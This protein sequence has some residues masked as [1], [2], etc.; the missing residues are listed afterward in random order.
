MNP[1]AQPGVPP[2]APAWASPR[3]DEQHLGVLSICHFIYAGLLAAAGVVGVLYIVFGVFLAASIAGAGAPGSGAPAAAV[4]G[5][6]VVI[7]GFIT[8]LLWAKAVLMVISGI[9]LRR[10]RYRMLSIV[11]A[12][13]SCAAV[14]LGTLLGAFTLVVLLRPSVT[15][16]YDAVAARGG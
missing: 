9:G 10:R 8:L 16:M 7:G 5:I 1:Y 3:E 15:A 11:L 12:C 6:F 14:P 4:G 13:I 2:Q